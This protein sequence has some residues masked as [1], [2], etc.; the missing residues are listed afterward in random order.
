MRG[1]QVTLETAVTGIFPCSPVPKTLH[2]R[3]GDLDSISGWR[4]KILHDMQRD[5]KLKEKENHYN[6][7][8]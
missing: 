6:N 5:Q 4:T 1:H 3:A 2:S 8:Q 7:E